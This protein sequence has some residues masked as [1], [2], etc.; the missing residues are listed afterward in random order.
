MSRFREDEYDLGENIPFN[1][2]DRSAP[3]S[4]HYETYELPSY[5]SG[6]EDHD[7]QTAQTSGR[8]DSLLCKDREPEYRYLGRSRLRFTMVMVGLGTAWFAV[9]LLQLRDKNLIYL[10]LHRTG[11]TT[12]L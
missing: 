4:S 8:E 1:T 9:S 12:Q 5:V 11:W 2:L 10:I 7:S 6:F 3:F